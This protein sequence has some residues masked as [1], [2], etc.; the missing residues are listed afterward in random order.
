MANIKNRP[1]GKVTKEELKT[2]QEQQQ[3]VNNILVEIGYQE[4]KKHSLLHHLG[5][6]N[7]TIDATKKELQ[8]KYGH[9]DID[10]STGD[11]KRNK[12]V[13]NKKD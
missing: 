10:L 6:A 5:D 7:A 9:V 11:W 4:S 1:L 12:D 13:G 2:I 8:E 3:K